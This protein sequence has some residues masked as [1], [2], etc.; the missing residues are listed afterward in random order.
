M[1]ALNSLDDSPPD[2]F[3]WPDGRFCLHKNDSTSRAST[4]EVH[5]KKIK[6]GSEAIVT[7]AGPGKGAQY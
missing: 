1:R 4:R 7:A 3:V 2:A 6:V 5:G